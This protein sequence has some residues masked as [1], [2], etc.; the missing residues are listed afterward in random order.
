MC[1]RGWEG[2][3]RALGRRVAV[4]GAQ[5]ERGV[6]GAERGDGAAERQ[7]DREVKRPEE[8]RFRRDKPVF[9]IKNSHFGKLEL[10]EPKLEN[11]V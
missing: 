9:R 4:I 7:K 5:G 3:S 10:F 1:E 2:T 6:V 11:Y 8:V